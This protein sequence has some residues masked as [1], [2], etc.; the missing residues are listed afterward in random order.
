[1]K[2]KNAKT[3]FFEDIAASF[4]TS[5]KNHLLPNEP[6]K[7]E[8]KVC[9]VVKKCNNP[10]TA[11]K[12]MDTDEE[13]KVA[14]S[15]M[16]EKYAKFLLDF[17]P[18]IQNYH[19]TTEIKSFILNGKENVTSPHYGGPVGNARQTYETE[20][21]IDCATRSLSVLFGE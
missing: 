20:F 2:D 17:A 15:D 7:F 9:S 19:K 10:I 4:N 11:P 5:R 21:C 1:M 18:P 8:K 16:R 12:L 13:L 3:D 6:M 14:L